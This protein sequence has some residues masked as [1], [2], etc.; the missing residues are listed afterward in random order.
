M[1][2]QMEIAARLAGE[3]GLSPAARAR[4]A[5]RGPEVSADED[6]LSALGV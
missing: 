1:S 3:A 5:L 6:D 4:K 2:K